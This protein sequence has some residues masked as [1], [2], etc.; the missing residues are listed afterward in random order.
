MRP[1]PKAEYICADLSTRSSL[2]PSR[3]TADHTF[4]GTSE[5]HLY[6]KPTLR[7]SGSP[8]LE[9]GEHHGVFRE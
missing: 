6:D 2:F 9:V 7:P 8:P 3:Q 4:Q 5:R 1:H